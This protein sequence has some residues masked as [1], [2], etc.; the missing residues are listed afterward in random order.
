M[1]KALARV[2]SP[3]LRAETNESPFFLPDVDVSVHYFTQQH[4]R[5]HCVALSSIYESKNLVGGALV[6]VRISRP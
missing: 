1:R 6:T 5:K 2:R 3:R 4:G